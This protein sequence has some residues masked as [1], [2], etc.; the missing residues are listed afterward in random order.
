VARE[1][2]RRRERAHVCSTPAHKVQWG[3][4]VAAYLVTKGI[5]AG[6][7]MLRRSRGARLKGWPL[8][9]GIEIVALLFTMITT[10]LVEGPAPAAQVPHAA[11]A[12]EHEE[13]LVKGASI[14][15]AS[16]GR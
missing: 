10:S 12:T 15:M 6:V 5:A 1:A 2:L 13:W 4:P 8:K 11:H 7:A 14:L 9:Y 16:A 3:W